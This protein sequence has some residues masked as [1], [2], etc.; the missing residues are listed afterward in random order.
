[1]G[2]LQCVATGGSQMTCFTPVA[3]AGANGLPVVTCLLTSTSAC[4][5]TLDGGSDSA[6]DGG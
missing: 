1:L 3:T 6:G 2:A 5:P 4:G